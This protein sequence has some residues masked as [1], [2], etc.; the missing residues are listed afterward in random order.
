MDTNRGGGG[1]GDKKVYLLVFTC[2][3]VRAIH[4]ELRQDVSAKSFVL[5]L[6]G[7]QIFLVSLSV[8]IVTM[9]DP[10]F[11]GSNTDKKYLASVEFQD[12][13]EIKHLTILL[14]APWMGSV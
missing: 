12:R 5:A 3:S 4:I 14:Y 11:A 9:Q 8:F 2:L 1:R 13:F 6:T 7:L 10:C